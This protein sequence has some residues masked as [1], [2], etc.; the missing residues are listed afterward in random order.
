M[1]IDITKQEPQ[2]RCKTCG[3]ELSPRQNYCREHKCNQTKV[4]RAITLICQ[5]K[6]EHTGR[7]LFMYLG[8]VIETG[9][10]K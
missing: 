8:E 6:V 7:C 1:T 9:L 3:R 5:K 2:G 10:R 4:Y